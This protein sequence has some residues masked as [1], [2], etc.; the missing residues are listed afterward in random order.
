MLDTPTA[1]LYKRR[2]TREATTRAVLD[3]LDVIRAEVPDLDAIVDPRPND[4]VP[5]YVAVTVAL[6]SDPPI[7]TT[8]MVSI[9]TRLPGALIRLGEIE[10]VLRRR[11]RHESRFGP[12]SSGSPS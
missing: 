8:T 7:G 9:G 2:A 10:R 5:L 6:T 11:Q 4:L 3:A 12:G 1:Q